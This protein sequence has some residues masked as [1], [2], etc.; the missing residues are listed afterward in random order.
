MMVNFPLALHLPVPPVPVAAVDLSPSPVFVLSCVSDGPSVR[1]TA[2]KKERKKKTKT[3]TRKK[4][5]T[6]LP[7]SRAAHCASLALPSHLDRHSGSPGLRSQV[8]VVQ[9]LRGPVATLSPHA[10]ALGWTRGLERCDRELAVGQVAHS[11]VHRSG[12]E[13][14]DCRAGQQQASRGERIQ[15]ARP[16]QRT[17]QRTGSP[18]ASPE[19]PCRNSPDP[20]SP[21]RRLRTRLASQPANNLTTCNL[22][23]GRQPSLSLY[24]PSLPPRQRHGNDA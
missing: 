14:P 8:C 2:G 4:K 6:A 1:D 16:A 18:P 9:H 13:A 12:F 7:A 17:K 11:P 19:C 20:P 22:Q 23:L 5:K 3:K 24:S 15:P 10:A 21:C